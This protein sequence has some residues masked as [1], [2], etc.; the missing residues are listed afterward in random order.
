MGRQTVPTRLTPIANF[1]QLIAAAREN[2]RRDG[3]HTIA[4]AGADQ[5]ESVLAAAH[6]CHDGMARCILVGDERRIRALAEEEQVDLGDI[7]IVHEADGTRAAHVAA[8]TV[9][10]G[11]ADLLMKGRIGTAEFMRGALDKDAGLRTGRLLSHVAVFEMPDLE[12]LILLS[13][14]GVV[15]APT[16]EQKVDII[17][18]AVDVAH[19]LGI[20]QPRVALLA[21]TEVVNAKIRATV[22]AAILS[23]MADRH[24]ITGCVVD[25]PLA[26]DSAMSIEAARMKGLESPVAGH[27]DVLVVPDIEAGN[28]LGKAMNYFGGGVLAGVVVGARCP[29]VVVSRSDPE[30]SKEVSMALAML[31]VEA[32]AKKEGHRR[33]EG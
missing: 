24:Q 14:A 30:W 18:N 9:C 33:G 3:P 19:A 2:T 7:K 28:M 23:K 16:L 22:E 21:A 32:E 5:R 10:R 13:D 15:V 11:E 25:G 6:A 12:R 8:L 31:V 4:I 29:L 26:V 1:Q 17:Q 20:A 27:A